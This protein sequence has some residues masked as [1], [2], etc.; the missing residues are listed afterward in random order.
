MSILYTVFPVLLLLVLGALLSVSTTSP[1]LIDQGQA[2][3]QSENI[4]ISP[5]DHENLGPETVTTGPVHDE[6][7]SA[8]ASLGTDG[9]QGKS[10]PLTKEK[11][12]LSP[13]AQW[14]QSSLSPA[15]EDSS[16][17]RP[18]RRPG[19]VVDLSLLST[20]RTSEMNSTMDAVYS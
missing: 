7:R 9:D 15:A 19:Q 2:G 10:A 17:Q 3:Q 12:P 4:I 6:S 18:I 1:G 14:S 20:N 5:A 16:D 11:P 8:P 13:L